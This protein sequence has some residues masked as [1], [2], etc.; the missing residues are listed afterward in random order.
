MQAGYFFLAADG[1]TVEEGLLDVNPH[2]ILVFFQSFKFNAHLLHHVFHLSGP[3][4][5][6]ALQGGL[7][8]GRHLWQPSFLDVV[9]GELGGLADEVVL[10]DEWIVAFGGLLALLDGL[11]GEAQ[12]QHRQCNQ[13][14]SHIWV[15]WFLWAK[16]GHIFRYNGIKKE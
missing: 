10:S 4:R 14:L 6:I 2:A 11:C 9:D 15:V 3:C 1:A 5:H 7:C 12:W 8:R 13:D 16:L